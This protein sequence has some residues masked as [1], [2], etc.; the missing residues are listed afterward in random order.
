MYAKFL[1][2]YCSHFQMGEKL[3]RILGNKIQNSKLNSICSPLQGDSQ[4]TEKALF[5]LKISADYRLTEHC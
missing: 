5:I 1:L 2:M 4:R 3:A